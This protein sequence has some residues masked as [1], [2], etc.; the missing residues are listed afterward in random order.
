MGKIVGRIVEVKG[1]QVKAKLF[2][3]LPPYL[4]ENGKRESAPKIN[5][6]VKTKIG[7]DTI[8]CQVVGEYSEEIGN[9]VSAHFLDLQVKGYLDRNKFIQGL[10]ILPIVSANIELLEKEDYDNIYNSGSENTIHIGND[11]FDDNKRINVDINKLIPSHIGVFG[12]TGSGKSN[13]LTKILQEYNSILKKFNTSN[14]KFL[15]LDLNNEYGK[16]AI[17]DED[18]K[19]IYSLS[20]KKRSRRKIPL[21]LNSLSE[22]DF[23]VL[24]N[25]SQKTQAPVVKNAYREMKKDGIERR[26][27]EYYL[28]YLKLIINNSRRTLFN[29]MR[30]YLKDYFTGLEGFFYHSQ[31]GKFYY[32][33]SNGIIVYS[34][35][36]EF[37]EIL[38]GIDLYLPEDDLDRF[39]FELYF[40][41]AHENENGVNLDFMMPLIARARKLIEDFRKIFNFTK[42]F[43]DIFCGKNV[44]VVQLGNVNKDMKEIVPSIITNNIFNRLSE[45]KEKGDIKQII[46]VVL[47]EA[48]NILY[49]NDKNI[50]SHES[51]LEVFEKVVKEGRK[52]GVFLML[53]SQRPSDISQTVIS[54]LHNYF[55]HKLV[56]PSDIAKIR[57]A[58]AYMDDAAL[59]FITILAPGECIVSGTAFQMPTFIYIQQVIKERRPNSENVILIGKN[60]IFK[61][62]RIEK[63]SNI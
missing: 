44:C 61:R 43:E 2:K 63:N 55:I 33:K 13:T 49:E 41:I 7:I 4:V 62:K 31:Q 60:G 54:Q 53:A 32:K 48:H 10:R 57:K 24:M 56:N 19:I 39:L 18:E 42:E 58:V 14:G 25:A 22:D 9:N 59:D 6:F 30:V 36:K 52:F 28:N 5:G 11:L 23:I 27:K 38:D 21:Q 46:N 12:N 40:S 1:L 15:V 50:L 45:E 16:S 35:N 3:L 47:D 37:E 51:V 20:T 17:C 8:I 34:D 26:D 29:S